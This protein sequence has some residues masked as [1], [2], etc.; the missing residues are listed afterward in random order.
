MNAL[1]LSAC[2]AGLLFLAAPVKAQVA[3]FEGNGRLAAI[4]VDG[5]PVE[6][7][8]DARVMGRGAPKPAD[9]GAWGADNVKYRDSA[10]RRTW[11]GDM[12]VEKGKS[13]PYELA[14]TEEGNELVFQVTLTPRPDAPL[15]N[16]QF[17]LLL[18]VDTFL[19]GTCSLLGPNGGAGTAPVTL[20]KD[21]GEPK[22]ARE[23]NQ[24]RVLAALSGAAR[25]AVV[26]A[27]GKTRVELSLTGP[28]AGS[29]SVRDCRPAKKDRYEVVFSFPP[30]AKDQSLQLTARLKVSAE[31][32]HKPATLRLDANRPRYRL[33][34]VGGNYCFGDD[35]PAADYTLTNLNVGW[36]RVEFTADQWWPTEDTARP[37]DNDKPSHKTHSDLMIAKRLS[38][39]GV[40]YVMSIWALPQW[41]Y[42]GPQRPRD[43]NG[44]VVP[45]ERWDKMADIITSYLIYARE[46][47]GA[48][49]RLFSFNEAD[50]GVFVKFTPEEARDLIKMLGARFAKL[51]LATKLLLGDTAAPEKFVP[52]VQAALADEEAMKYV[53]AMAFHSWGGARPAEYAAIRGEAVKR[54]L[55]LLVTEVGTDSAAW[56]TPWVF[57]DWRYAMGELRLYQELLL[58]ACPQ[59]TMQWEFNEDYSLVKVKRARDGQPQPAKPEVVPSG[60]FWVMK[61]F[62][63][64]TP[65]PADA[66]ETAS[67]TPSILFTAFRGVG[68]ESSG[69]ENGAPQKASSRKAASQ[70]GLYVL[71]VANLGGPRKVTIQ[72][73]P[74]GVTTAQVVRS[75]QREA[76]K[77]LEAVLVK[78]GAATLDL[79]GQCLTTL[80]GQAES[81]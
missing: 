78:D 45:R 20:P 5:E 62:C 40:P 35:G 56:R 10:G 18:P 74:P 61:H 55:P 14:V 54:K 67:D 50:L 17:V 46:K 44:R 12:T 21:V 75:S 43:Y 38:A 79:A 41:I 81:R 70:K 22:E 29:A 2:A 47:Y 4:D 65:H 64:L 8:A 27:V 30:P 9:L 33:D 68:E 49:P 59:G 63:N 58:H 42:E 16:V 3:H 39:S 48:E 31:S 57:E 52:Y 23:S 73:L 37:S 71:H 19:G 11:A 6:V 36:A 66:L 7:G 77:A 72:G 53:G 1:V 25:T 76:F 34:G 26:A 24:P 32:D 13:C 69:A 80:S 15:E 51:G 28:G 60:R